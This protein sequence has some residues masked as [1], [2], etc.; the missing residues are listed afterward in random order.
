MAERWIT[1]RGRH[2]LVDDDGSIVKNENI[3]YKKLTDEDLREEYD[4]KYNELS[5]EEK[6]AIAYY[7]SELSQ[8]YKYVKDVLN[9]YGDD[10]EKIKEWA[11]WNDTDTDFTIKELDSVMSKN[12]INQNVKVIRI[13][14]ADNFKNIK[15][16]EN[17]KINS[18]VSTTLN[19]F[20]A[21]T[22]ENRL[23]R[24]DI[25]PLYMEIDIPKGTRGFYIGKNGNNIRN[26][27]ELLLDR[28]LEYKVKKYNK[29][30]NFI[31]LEVINR[32]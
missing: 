5:I 6:R 9:K 21:T 28:N 14:N 1:W 26:E 3:E 27:S 24:N 22:Y 30:E 32:S 11:E 25:T 18:Y 17:I 12:K 13:E 20:I 2:I 29:N 4:K 15:K 23:K 7:T 8:E 31:H 19:D 16:G 10:F